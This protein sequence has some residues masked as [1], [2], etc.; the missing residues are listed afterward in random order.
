[1]VYLPS[2]MVDFYGFHGQKSNKSTRCLT[3]QHQN[4]TRFAKIPGVRFF[5]VYYPP[6]DLSHIPPKG[7]FGKS[8]TQNAIFRGI[9]IRSLEGN[10]YTYVFFFK[11]RTGG[12]CRNWNTNVQQRLLYIPQQNFL[13]PGIFHLSKI[14]IGSLGKKSST[15]EKDC[16]Q[17]K[18]MVEDVQTKAAL[19]A[20]FFFASK[21]KKLPFSPSS[22]AVS[23]KIWGIVFQAS[24]VSRVFAWHPG[25]LCQWLFPGSLNRW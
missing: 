10:M 21:K 3:P 25:S 18:E 14:Q 23:C 8:S 12:S 11:K 20:L 15:R 1:M 24:K 16:M 2:R 7:K 17:T 4:K 9:C 19:W 5:D 13:G 22:S 6:G